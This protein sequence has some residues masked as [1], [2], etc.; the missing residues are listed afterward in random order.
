MKKNKFTELYIGCFLY[1]TKE[2]PSQTLNVLNIKIYNNEW[3]RTWER[4]RKKKFEDEYLL[5]K[6]PIEYLERLKRKF[7]KLRFDELHDK[8]Q[9]YKGDS[10]G[11]WTILQKFLS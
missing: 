11:P 10:G 2:L 9:G 5:S 6:K 1:E 8:D 4:S 7:D 3:T